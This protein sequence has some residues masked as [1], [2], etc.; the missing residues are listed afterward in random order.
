M[1]ESHEQALQIADVY[2]EALFGLAKQAGQIAEV[3]GELEE[4]VRLE[5]AERDFA[6]FM[7]SDAVDDD[8]REDS[9]EKM[10]RGRLS[11]MVLNTLQ[12]MNHHDR[13]GLLPA[14]LRCYVLRQ[15][16]DAGQIEVVATS[17]VDLDE[18]QRAEIRRWVAE[19]SGYEPLVSYVV[20]PDIIGGLVVKIGDQRFDYSVRRHLHASRAQLLD[21]SR[22]G[23]NV[24]VETG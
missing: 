4:L 17:A 21:R 7:R 3:R 10:F 15:E 13:A 5:E 22:R 12:V 14:L 23:L 6:A 24:S 1:A 16:R 18:S 2:A 11:D 8:K 9:L 20:D 19:S